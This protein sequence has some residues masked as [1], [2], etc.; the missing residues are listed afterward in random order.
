[1]KLSEISDTVKVGV[2][3]VAVIGGAASTTWAVKANT[4]AVQELTITLKEQGQRISTL[5]SWKI[6]S[7]A[8]ARGRRDVHEEAA[9]DGPR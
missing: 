1:V 7:E 2:V 5:E 9:G 4:E 6:D 3:A 8:Y